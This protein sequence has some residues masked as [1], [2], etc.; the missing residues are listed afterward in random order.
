M[1]SS[2]PLRNKGATCQG[3]SFQKSRMQQKRHP[4]RVRAQHLHQSPLEDRHY[5]PSECWNSSHADIQWTALQPDFFEG[6]QLCTTVFTLENGQLAPF[7]GV[8]TENIKTSWKKIVKR[9]CFANYLRCWSYRSSFKMLQVEITT[10]GDSSIVWNTC[11]QL[12]H[13]TE[14]IR[15]GVKSRA[16]CF[17]SHNKKCMGLANLIWWLIFFFQYPSKWM[18]NM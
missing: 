5:A 2:Y 13:H 17:S 9:W 7:S 3:F 12:L 8:K 14:K 15:S 18:Q 16:V 1:A 11:S 10:A 4:Q 6:P